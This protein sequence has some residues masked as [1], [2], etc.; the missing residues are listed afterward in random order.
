[1]IRI[2]GCYSV[3]GEL[4]KVMFWI[5]CSTS[6]EAMRFAAQRAMARIFPIFYFFSD[7]L[8]HGKVFGDVSLKLLYL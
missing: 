7:I 6:V 1:M 2:A 4:F 5:T 3:F 8:E